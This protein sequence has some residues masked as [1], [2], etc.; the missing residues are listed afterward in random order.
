MPRVSP[1]LQRAAVSFTLGPLALY[2]IYL[3]G[4][5]YFIPIAAILTAAAIEYAQIMRHMRLTLSLWVLLPAV[6]VQWL[7]AQWPE[8]NL[9][10]PAL[11]LGLF[12]VMGYALWLYERQLSQSVTADWMAMIGGV[13][14][15]GWLGGH[16]FRLRGLDSFAWQ[17][18]MLAMLTTWIA[19]SAAYV[20]GKFLAGK[21]LL[22][23][24]QLSPRLSPN[25]TIEGYAGGVVFAL[26]T[27]VILAPILKLPLALAVTLSLIIA[28]VSPLGDLGISLLKRE[29]G[30]KDSGHLFP[31]HG[32]ALDR[33]DSLVWS[34]TIAYYFLYF[35]V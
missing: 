10:V 14:L 21:F 4:L 2:L 15:L 28:A 35:F 26:V 3:G 7:A 34:V 29:A 25:K 17:W 16:F 23:R 32:G 1:F 20:V 13:L 11:A 18:T 22:G 24:H 33:I 30:V 6:G 9:F 31:G 19:D 12:W 27:A 5:P 8:L